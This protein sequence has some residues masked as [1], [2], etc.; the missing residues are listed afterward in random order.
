MPLDKRKSDS[1]L[2]D[3]VK[4]FSLCPQQSVLSEEISTIHHST[5]VWS[6]INGDLRSECVRVLS[7]T[8]RR[9]VHVFV[10]MHVCVCVI[11]VLRTDH[12]RVM[13]SSEWCISPQWL[14]RYRGI[15]SF[16]QGISVWHF[17]RKQLPPSASERQ[18]CFL[19][20]SHERMQEHH[21]STPEG[22]L[23]KGPQRSC[24]CVST[25]LHSP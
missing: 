10:C 21:G 7:C 4:A 23:L 20:G 9:C 15:Q 3:G 16:T 1:W 25:P 22:G 17:T 6:L 13:S 24:C 5:T 18:C 12:E 14:K 8:G 19:L 11:P 2:T